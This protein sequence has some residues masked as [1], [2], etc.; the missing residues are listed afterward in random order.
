MTP[1]KLKGFNP[2]EMIRRKLT[3]QQL[4]EAREAFDMYD[5]DKDG[6]ITTKEVKPAMRAFGY[7]PNSVV[8]EKIKAKGKSED[9]EGRLNYQEQIRYSFQSKNMYKDLKTLTLIMTEKSRSWNY[10]IILKAYTCLPRM[11]KLMKLSSRPIST[12]MGS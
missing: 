12:M 7:N 4:S 8:S 9:V 2:N 6:I 11:K 10:V 1:L 5:D 3:L